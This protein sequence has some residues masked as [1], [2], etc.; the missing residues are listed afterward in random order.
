MTPGPTL[1]LQSPA[2]SQP[3]Q[4]LT[5]GSGN[6]FGARYWS[7]GKCE[8]PMLP[9]APL[10]CKSPSEGKLFWVKD[11]KVIGEWDIFDTNDHPEWEHLDE[12]ATP[13]QADFIK[14]L[15]TGLAKSDEQ[16]LYVRMRL[17]WAGNDKIRRGK[18][19]TLTKDLLA[20]LTELEKILSPEK[21]DQRLL[22]AEALRELS[23]FEEALHLLHGKIPK[24]YE[25]VRTIIRDLALKS[26]PSLV[27]IHEP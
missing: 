9:E 16:I 27:Q 13:S 10:L 8:A 15:K 20:N 1:I 24:N 6:T 25:H 7:D 21:V 4:Y 19:A 26:D 22:K 18:H 12:V 5:I 14:A 17:W 3:I 2:L 11:C 23:R